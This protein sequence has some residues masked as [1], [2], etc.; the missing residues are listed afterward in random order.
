LLVPVFG[1]GSA[2]LLLGETLTLLQLAGAALIMAG[3][4][5]NVFGVRFRKALPVR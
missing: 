1:M 5:I 2:V 3:L 4:Y